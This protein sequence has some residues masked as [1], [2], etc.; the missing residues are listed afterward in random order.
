LENKAAEVRPCYERTAR[1]LT[2]SVARRFRIA[3]LVCTP[4]LD[5]HRLRPARALVILTHVGVP[6][7]RYAFSYGG[8]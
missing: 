4:F 5:H 1:T 3:S 8:S 2:R 7:L 6:Y